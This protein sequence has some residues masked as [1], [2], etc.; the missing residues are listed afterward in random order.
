VFRN[1]PVTIHGSIFLIELDVQGDNV[2]LG[3]DW[4]AKYKTT[5]HCER[6]LLTLITP[7]GEKM[8]YQ[9]SNSQKPTPIILATK[10]FKV[11]K[12]GSQGY[13]CALEALDK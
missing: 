3:M 9:G 6:K 10:A 13:L 1:Y 8:E 4:L 7:E 11:L 2:I 5:I 12:K